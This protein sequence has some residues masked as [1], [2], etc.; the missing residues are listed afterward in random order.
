MSTRIEGFI[1]KV[2]DAPKVKDINWMFNAPAVNFSQSVVDAK[3]RDNLTFQ[4]EAGLPARV[5]RYSIG[6]CCPWCDSLEGTYE[7]PDVPQ[8]IWQRHDNCNCFIE[9]TPRGGGRKDILGGNKKAW[10]LVGQEELEARRNFEGINTQPQNSIFRKATTIEEA[11][12]YA[13]ETLGLSTADYKKLNIDVANMVNEEITKAYNT[14]G[15]LK[16]LGV[17]D[18][19]RVVTGKHEYVGAYNV[20]FKS[21]ILPR[22][23]TGYKSSVANMRKT[24]I[25]NNELGFWSTNKP[26]H[27]IRHELGHAI[28]KL[29][30]TDEMTPTFDALRKDIMDS[31]GA[32]K[33]SIEETTEEAMKS[34][35]GKLSYYGMRDNSELIAESVAE[36]LDGNPRET[37][38]GVVERLLK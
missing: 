10:E 27:T 11:E 15:N 16:E 6:G 12:K 3:M 24:A 14:F 23:T 2:S 7:Y 1:N 30:Y 36:F 31:A 35:G 20:A 38:I 4:G 21:I 26:E 37:A 25:Q 34:I 18:E 17:L 29:Y 8:E 13:K 28:E 32:V 19:I 9:Y 5:H 22:Q 33:W